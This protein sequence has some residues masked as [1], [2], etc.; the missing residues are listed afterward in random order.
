MTDVTH[1]DDISH[2]QRSFNLTRATCCKATESTGYKDPTYT[3][4]RAQAAREGHHFAGYHFIHA[5]NAVAQ[6]QFAHSVIGTTPAM[7]DIETYKSG[8]STRCAS[9]ADVVAF[10]KEFRSLGGTMNILYLPRWVWTGYWKSVSLA[11]L[12]ALGCKILNSNYQ[13][14]EGQ[15][16]PGFDSFGAT[17]VWALQYTSTPWDKN[18]AYMT[19]AKAWEGWSGK[20]IPV[21]S[22]K[23]TITRELHRGMHGNDVKLVQG[24][25]GVARDGI[26]GSNTE[27]HVKTWQGKHGLTKDG[28]V[29]RKTATAMGF[30]YTGK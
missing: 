2:Y 23:L 25:V 21:L 5:G 8:G 30:K 15:H 22:P 1:W 13:H 27:T 12:V 19:W 10:V 7:L 16:T 4:Y 29:G 26:F 6:A 3:T 17:P 11:P 14:G 18:V 28:I 20:H 9:M 24:K